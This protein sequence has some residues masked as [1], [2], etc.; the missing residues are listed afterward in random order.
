NLCG[1]WPG[2][3]TASATLQ[4]PLP[5]DPWRL[6]AIDGHAFCVEEDQVEIVSLS[7]WRVVSRFSGTYVDQICTDTHWVGVASSMGKLALDY[8]NTQGR[9]FGTPVEL[10][11][12]AGDYRA[13]AADGERL[14]V[15]ARNG[16][17]LRVELGEASELTPAD[18]DAELLSL[19]TQK[20]G[21]VA[22]IRSGGKDTVRLY[23]F[24]GKLQKQLALGFAG[25]TDYPVHIG[26]RLYVI[27]AESRKLMTV[28][29]KKLELSGSADLPG[30][31]ITSF[32]GVFRKDQHALLATIGDGEH[33]RLYVL[34]PKTGAA[35]A[36]CD[37][38]EPGLHVL[39]AE[40]KVV[41]AT[42]AFYQNMIRV[43]DPFKSEQA[44]RAA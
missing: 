44:A 29:L 37:V 7:S 27:D 31:T 12:D 38:K 10:P 19:S 32:C 30:S 1:A 14:F 21:L 28:N 17:I 34:D 15:A 6:A 18:Q 4:E 36:V 33:T 2:K 35:M 22:L 8:R 13:S 3:T 24:D 5:V 41:V 23:G 16:R 40:S 26:E 42:S 25:A 11:M 43:F 39:V 9:Q 20:N